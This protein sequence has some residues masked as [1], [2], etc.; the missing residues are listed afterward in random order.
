MRILFHATDFMTKGAGNYGG[1]GHYRVYSIAKY[2][3]GDHL[4]VNQELESYAKEQG[5]TLE[6]LISDYD[7][8]YMHQTTNGAYFI[9]IFKAVKTQRKKFIMGTDD[10]FW[11]VEPH[12]PAFDIVHANNDEPL[13]HYTAALSMADL[14]I[15]STHPLKKRIEHFTA[16][17][18][19]PDIIVIPNMNDKDVFTWRVP[20]KRKKIKIGWMGSITHDKDLK[21]IMPAIN[22]IMD[23]YQNVSFHFAGGIRKETAKHVFSAISNKNV[24]KLVSEGGVAYWNAEKTFPEFMNKLDWDI[25]LCPLTN[26]VFNRCKSHIKWMES[27]VLGAAV[28]VSKVYP[29]HLP[30]GDKSTVIHGEFGLVAE[31]PE[32]WY[33]HIKELIEK[34]DLRH[35]MQKKSRKHIEQHWQIKDNIG[36]YEAAFQA[37]LLS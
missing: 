17:V 2:L 16:L 30:V 8:L 36:Q 32:D 29:Y 37:A 9:K 27:T 1:V 14:V 26:T 21:M 23:E 7:A 11:D 19:V 31:T 25:S 33:Q 12:N 20:T 6:E 22:K 13:R 18:G 35:G 28:V 15:A 24:K 3:P 10:T 34:P 5:Q 4:V